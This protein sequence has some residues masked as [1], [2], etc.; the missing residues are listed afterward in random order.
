MCQR[1][2]S[3]NPPAAARNILSAQNGRQ[4]IFYPHSSD[5]AENSQQ[6]NIF[7]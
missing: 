4:D 1:Q 3:P 2:R 7:P 6:L 5:S